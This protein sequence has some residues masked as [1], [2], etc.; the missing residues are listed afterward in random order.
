MSDK[1]SC[2]RQNFSGAYVSLSEC[3]L[4][5]PAFVSESD[6]LSN[7]T[8]SGGSLLALDSLITASTCLACMTTQVT[9]ID[10][11]GRLT[12]SRGIFLFHTL[13]FVRHDHI[14]LRAAQHEDDGCGY[15]GIRGQPGQDRWG[16]RAET[17]WDLLPALESGT[18]LTCLGSIGFTHEVLIV[19]CALRIIGTVAT[20]C[21]SSANACSA[22]A[23]V[24]MPVSSSSIIINP[25]LCTRACDQR[26]SLSIELV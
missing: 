22:C 5:R 7:S 23:C 14:S 1:L 20:S 4:N 19:S 12:L 6:R 21:P 16:P 26:V 18:V 10:C 15:P 9:V 11:C 25:C 17:R 13:A 2:T 24:V 3:Q 8:E